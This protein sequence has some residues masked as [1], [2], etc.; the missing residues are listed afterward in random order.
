MIIR[1]ENNFSV[2]DNCLTLFNYSHYNLKQS[3]APG[4]AANCMND[5][6]GLK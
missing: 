5:T 4:H 2:L 1:L 6:S 3:S